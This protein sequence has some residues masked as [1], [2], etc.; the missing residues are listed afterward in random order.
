MR[1]QLIFLSALLVSMTVFGQKNE[2]KTAEKAIKA[3]DFS[4]AIAAINQ[5]ESLIGSADQKTKAK[6]YYLKGIA[7]YQ[8]GAAENVEEVGAA[9][10]QLINFEKESN[11]LK[12]TNEVGG[13]INTMVQNTA[14]KASKDYETAVE[15]KLPE[16]Y[17]K[18]ANGFAQVYALSP[19]DTTFLD[20][21]ALVYFYGKDYESSKNAYEKLLDLNY[22][23]I[24]TI[25]VATDKESGEEVTYPDK[26]AMDLQV[27]LGIAENPRE[28]VKDSRR[29][30]IFKNLAQNYSMLE[31]SEKAL[32]V[33]AEGREE[34]P[35]SYSLLIEEANMYYKAGNNE[36]FK[37]KLEEAIDLNPTEPT[38]HYNVGVMNMGQGNLDE[39]IKFF[40]TAIEL[41]P[42]YADA[43]NNIGAAIIEK[44]API[45]EEM[46]KNL[47]DFAKYDKLQAQ[48][49]EIYKEAIPYY[50]KAY[51]INGKNIN[52]VQTLMGL[53]EN[54][55]MTDKL[56]EIKAVYEELKQ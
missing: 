25:F 6:Y 15:T 27:K 24:S 19:K 4:S 39:A 29:E 22:T 33:I 41:D 21:A 32:K 50:E 43:Y 10:N 40:E 26:K 30:L 37:I 3:N 38:L 55:E 28:E 17:V 2:L 1:K 44:A 45:I 52:I 12:Y 46:N 49:F 7:L 18:A 56:N 16:D 34:F 35:E 20:N 9:F 13:L 36:M 42:K 8:N 14:S 23:G 5:A 51:E 11:K 54:L 31:D 48:Q 53:Y 47:S